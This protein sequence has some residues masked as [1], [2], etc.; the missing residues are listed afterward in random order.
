MRLVEAMVLLESYLFAG[1]PL[2]PD[3]DLSRPDAIP[4]G[5]S[6]PAL[7]AEVTP[8]LKKPK[9]RGKGKAKSKSSTGLS[10]V[11]APN[12]QPNIVSSP[13]TS[14]SSQTQLES[15]VIVS[16]LWQ[17]CVECK[18]KH[19]S[20]QGCLP[21]LE[22]S[23]S[24]GEHTSDLEPNF[25]GEKRWGGSTT[26]GMFESLKARC[27]GQNC[28]GSDSENVNSI[29]LPQQAEVVKEVYRIVNSKV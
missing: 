17:R 6:S 1:L 27:A 20:D 3:I 18:Q 23:E 8:V 24:E 26:T 28:L 19:W 10:C 22:M 2:Q 13:E 12:R 9:S 14:N 15:A 5:S 29:V 25:Y 4:M 7:E 11:E 16:R 21:E